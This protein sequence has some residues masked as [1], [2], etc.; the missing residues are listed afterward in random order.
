MFTYSV[1]LAREQTRNLI[2]TYIQMQGTRMQQRITK[3]TQL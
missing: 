3:L 1:A 2:Y